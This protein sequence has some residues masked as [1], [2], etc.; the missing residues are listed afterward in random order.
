MLDKDVATH[1]LGQDIRWVVS[2]RD[3]LKRKV[4]LSHAILDPEIRGRQVPHLPQPSTA[5]YADGCGSIR[6]YLEFKGYAK[7]R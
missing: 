7:S 5:A 1:M 3:F 4:L 2:T 6:T